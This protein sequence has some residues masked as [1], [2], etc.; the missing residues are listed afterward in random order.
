MKKKTGKNQFEEM[1]VDVSE[2]SGWRKASRS[3]NPAEAK[4][5]ARRITI[6]IDRDLIGNSEV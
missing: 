5:P 3:V 6:N 1:P 4:L 2:L